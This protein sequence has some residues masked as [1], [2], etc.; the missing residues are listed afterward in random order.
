MSSISEFKVPFLQLYLFFL[1][2]RIDSVVLISNITKTL[3][4]YIYIYIY[5]YTVQ[6]VY[7]DTHTLIFNMQMYVSLYHSS[8]VQ[9]RIYIYICMYYKCITV[10]L[11]RLRVNLDN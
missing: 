7:T 9:L 6:D 3:D 2:W 11:D 10:I 4:K 8:S 1:L 5:I